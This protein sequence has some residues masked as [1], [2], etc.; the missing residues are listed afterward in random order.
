M[1]GIYLDLQNVTMS[2]LKQQDILMSTGVIEN[3][4]APIE[5]Q[6]YVMKSIKQESGTLLP[7]LAH[8]AQ[9]ISSNSLKFNHLIFREALSGA[10]QILT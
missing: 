8:I 7:T 5:A 3:P 1:L 4:E 6:R 2:K 10:L 9:L